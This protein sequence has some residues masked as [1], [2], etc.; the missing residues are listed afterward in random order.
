MAYQRKYATREERSRAM[1]EA[2]KKGAAALKAS[3][4]FKGGRPKSPPDKLP[5]AS[6]PVKTL[7]VHETDRNVFKRIAGLQGLSL[8]EFM[9]RLADTLKARNPQL[10]TEA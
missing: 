4:N 3:G 6:I 2:G 10:F 1:S 9:H 8:V 5:L 7:S